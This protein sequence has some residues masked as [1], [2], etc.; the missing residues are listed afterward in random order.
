V[1]VL[2]I[3]VSVIGLLLASGAFLLWAGNGLPYPDAT[4]DLLK[5][6]EEKA[7]LLELI[8]LVGIATTVTGSFLL[9]RNRRRGEK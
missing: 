4:A 3:A 9:W 6:Q 7:A 5:A 8:M 2:A 1:R